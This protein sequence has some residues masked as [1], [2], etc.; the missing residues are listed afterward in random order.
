MTDAHD[1]GEITV[2]QQFFVTWH[3][4]MFIVFLWFYFSLF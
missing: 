4:Q 3:Y 1:Y 2:K